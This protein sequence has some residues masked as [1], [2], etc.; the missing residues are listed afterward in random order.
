MNPT[1]ELRERRTGEFLTSM[2]LY[3]FLKTLHTQT[4]AAD[5]FRFEDLLIVID[6]EEL[7]PTAC[8]HA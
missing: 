1:I 8:G 2:P 7:L 3:E 5:E 6:G 4:P